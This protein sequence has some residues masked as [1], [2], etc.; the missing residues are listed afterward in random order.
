MV[1]KM[2]LTI[3]AYVWTVLSHNLAKFSMVIVLF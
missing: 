2:C 3:L 1:E